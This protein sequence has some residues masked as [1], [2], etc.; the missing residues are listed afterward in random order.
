MFESV[1]CDQSR[2]STSRQELAQ[3]LLRASEDTLLKNRRE[4]TP[5][6]PVMGFGKVE[7]GVN[8]EEEANLVASILTRFCT[9]VYG[10]TGGVAVPTMTLGPR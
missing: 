6:N 7:L 4:H 8:D 1:F 3:L 10:A 2:D 9:T 5:L